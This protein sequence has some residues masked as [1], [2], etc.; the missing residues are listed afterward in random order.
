MSGYKIPVGPLHVAMEEPM[1]FR[2]E[3]EGET[4]Q[5]LEI[6]A[7]HVHRGIEYL[8]SK[9]SLHQNIVV[10]ERICSLCSNS[11]PFTYI[12]ALETIAGITVPERVDYLRVAADEIKRIASHMFNIGIIAHLTGFDSLFMQI[13]ET[14]EIMQDV[15]ETIFGNRMDLG[16]NCI[17]GVRYD[18]SP[19]TRTYLAQSL[20]RISGPMAEY[21]RLFETNGSIL[22]RTKGVGVLSRK[23]ARYLGVIGPVARASGLSFDVRKAAPYAVYD[24]LEFDIPCFEDGDV[25]ARAMV[26]IGEVEQSIRILRQVL[27]D[28]PAGPNVID[29]MPP[30]PAGEAVARS[31]APRGELIYYL[32]TDGSDKP[33][34]M[35]W[36][37]PSYNNWKALQRMMAGCAIADIA[38]IVGSIDPCISCTER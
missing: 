17:G 20:D 35:K 6:V 24:R 14:R 36:R 16:A 19:K 2:V 28:M 15:K 31:E 25:W 8:V 12:M 5:S 22:R 23:D 26:R 11:H 29:G 3:V 27:R 21:R 30:V 13:M 1:F 32:K 38:L 9:R 10:T 37:V 4:V 18:M 33:E 7:G 34:R